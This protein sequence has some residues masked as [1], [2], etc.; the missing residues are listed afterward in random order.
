METK[1]RKGQFVGYPK[2]S[3]GYYFYLPTTQRVVISRDVIFLEKEFI[4]EGG[5]GR[6]LELKF[7]NFDK[8]D[9]DPSNEPIPI[10]DFSTSIP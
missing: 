3:F 5:K 6:K 8:I 4:L 9:I 7:E 1:S 2:D 10:D